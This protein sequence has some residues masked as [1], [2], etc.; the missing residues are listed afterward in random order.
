MVLALNAFGI[1]FEYNRR[2]RMNWEWIAQ[3]VQ[4]TLGFLLIARLLLL[5]LH[6]IYEIFCAFLLVDILGSLFWFIW[7]DSYSVRSHI[8][9]RSGWLVGRVAFWILMVWTVY[10]LL[11]AILANLDGIYRLSRKVLKISFAVAIIIGLL[12]AIPE[13]WASGVSGPKYTNP[14]DKLVGIGMIFDRVLSSAALLVLLAILILLLWFPV[15]ISRNLAVFSAGLLVYFAAK[16]TVMLGRNFWSH[17][18]TRGVGIAITFAMSVCIAYWAM[19]IS[20]AGERVRTRPGHAW[21]PAQQ[22]RLMV[23][24]EALNASLLR[25]AR[26]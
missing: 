24:L 18:S 12:S 4:V 1:G 6:R 20:R 15:Q 5:R 21:K 19:F 11:A 23:Q 17:D 13:Y 25:S 8:D 10:A 3:I 14:L 2:A 22:E 9:Y 26:R 16:T 7:N